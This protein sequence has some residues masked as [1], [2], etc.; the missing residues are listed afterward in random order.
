MN[1]RKIIRIMA[2][3]VLI[4]IMFGFYYLYIRLPIINGYAAKNMCSCVF[5]AGREQKD[6][7]ANDL[8][9]SLVKYASN[10]IDFENKTVTS[11]FWGMRSQMAFYN[12]K[13][14]CSLVNTRKPFNTKELNITPPKSLAISFLFSDFESLNPIPLNINQDKLRA[15]IGNHFIEVE[16][17]NTR[18]TRA[19]VVLYGN[20][21]IAEEYTEG[22]DK[23]T[24]Q[25]GWSM[26]KSIM[27]SL[28][29][30]LV[31][32]GEIDIN[33]PTGIETWQNDNRKNITW[34]QLLQMNSGLKWE[35][36]YGSIS[37]VTKML[38]T[39]D[40]SYAFAVDHQLDGT[41]G[42]S[43]KYSSG[44]SNIL[45]GLIRKQLDDDETYLNF[46]TKEL[47]N[48]IG[49]ESMVLETDPS[50]TIVGSSYAWATPRDWAKYGLLYLQNGKVADQ[51]I[52]PDWWTE[53]TASPAEGSEGKYGA[54]FWKQNDEEFPN[55]PK[56]MYFAD[57]FQ[58]QRIFIIPSKNLVIVRFG[59]ANKGDISFNQLLK[60]VIEAV[61]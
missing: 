31:Q 41:P 2:V 51:Q 25:L 45:S 15:A 52:F 12:E 3:I 60:E 19:I 29:G 61:E 13:T 20:Q 53:Y 47:F 34:N 14:G 7:E 23:N 49:A 48:W 27:S 6:I 43:W 30:I 8:N 40:D 10:T 22:F 44:T 37:D 58:G 9:F 50:G 21:L 4:G 57:G 35:E 54:Q 11:S 26:A 28:I 39:E 33:Q 55:V 56:D 17:E 59:L 42:K 38:Y 24:K 36:D 32:Q 18:N 5:V 46:A 16:G 1:K